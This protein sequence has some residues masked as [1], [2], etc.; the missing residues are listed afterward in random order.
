MRVTAWNNGGEGY[1]I[2]VGEANRERYFDSG[3][4]VIEVEIAGEMCPFRLAGSFWRDCPE[5]RG[6]P[7]GDWLKLQGLAYWAV[8][9]PPEFELT[10]LG[11]NRF[12]LA[13]PDPGLQPSLFEKR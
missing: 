10:P 6:K 13:P 9:N 12:R 7:I 1:G 5:F 4:S 8:G 2:R 11:G 3:W